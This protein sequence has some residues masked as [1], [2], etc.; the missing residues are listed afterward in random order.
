MAGFSGATGVPLKQ[1]QDAIAQSTAPDTDVVLAWGNYKDVGMTYTLS[2][3]ILT[4]HHIDVL[5]GY[6]SD[7]AASGYSFVS[8]AKNIIAANNTLTCIYYTGNDIQHV[9]FQ[10]V[11][12]TH[13]KI[14]ACSE[15][16]LGIREIRAKY[17]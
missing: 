13:I 14:I 5:V 15:A 17:Y 9:V 12:G 8:F 7:S 10:I 16:Y 6:S 2:K 4:A 1:M 3:S 11:D